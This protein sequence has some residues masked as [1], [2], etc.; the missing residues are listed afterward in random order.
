MGPFW[1]SYWGYPF[2]W[3]GYW[4]DYFCPYGSVY[5]TLYPTAAYNYS[6]ADDGQYAANYCTEPGGRC[7]RAPTRGR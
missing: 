7:Q 3:G 2:G 5:A 1:F 6:Y 4:A